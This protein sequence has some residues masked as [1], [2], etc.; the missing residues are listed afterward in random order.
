MILEISKI[1]IYTFQQLNKTFNKNGKR[2]EIHDHG[3]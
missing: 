1:V 3:W 2:K